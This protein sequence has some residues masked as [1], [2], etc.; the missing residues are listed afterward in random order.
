MSSSQPQPSASNVDDPVGDHQAAPTATARSDVEQTLGTCY[1]H[2]ASQLAL[3]AWRRGGVLHVPAYGD[4]IH[5]I[6]TAHGCSGQD[7]LAAIATLS[8]LTGDLDP[9]G[10]PTLT[11][12]PMGVSSIGHANP[13]DDSPLWRMQRE[14]R[15]V[16]L[17]TLQMTPEHWRRFTAHF[18]SEG[19]VAPLHTL[20]KLGDS[21]SKISGLVDVG[22][23]IDL[24]RSHHGAIALLNTWD[25]HYR[26]AA[27]RYSVTS[28]A[29]LQIPRSKIELHDVT[30][31]A[32]LSNLLDLPNIADRLVRINASQVIF[33]NRI[34][35]VIDR[36]LDT[37]MAQRL[38]EHPHAL[39]VLGYAD[40]DD[41]HLVTERVDV[42][43]CDTTATDIRGEERLRMLMHV[44]AAWETLTDAGRRPP[45]R[46]LDPSMVAGVG[47]VWKLAPFEISTTRDNADVPCSPEELL[48]CSHA[49]FLQRFPAYGRALVTNN[50]RT[51]L[52]SHIQLRRNAEARQRANESLVTA[53]G[54][55]DRVADHIASVVKA[56]YRHVLLQT[57]VEDTLW[58]ESIEESISGAAGK[59]DS[60]AA[61]LRQVADGFFP[62]E[63]P[64][65]APSAIGQKARWHLE[66]VTVPDWSPCA[67]SLTTKSII[68]KTDIWPCLARM[69]CQSGQ[70]SPQAM[71]AAFSA[72]GPS[73]ASP[74]QLRPS[75]TFDYEHGGDRT[76]TT[77]GDLRGL[78]SIPAL[79][80]VWL[81][82]TWVT[83]VRRLASAK[84]L[85]QLHLSGTKVTTEGTMGL[86][87]VPTL[88]TLVLFSTLVTDVRH[89]ASAKA[90]KQL[91]LSSTKMTTEGTMGLERI[92]TLETLDLSG[93]PITDVR[94]LASSKALKLLDLNR[95]KVTVEGTMGLERI[96][97]LEKLVLSFTPI[98]DVR[99]LAS[100]KAL[101]HLDLSS[102]KVTTEGTLGLECMPT[103]E[104]LL[105]SSVLIAD[106]RHLASAKALKH[107]DLRS[108]GMTTEGTMGLERIP[109]LE[110]LVL[111]LTSITDVRHLASAKALKHLDLSSTKVTTEGTM[112]LECMPTL[113][114]LLLSSVLIADVR[115]LASAKA[116]KHLDLSSTKVTTEG[117]TELERIPTLEM[118]LLSSTFV[119]DVRHLAS[120]KALK[121]LDLNSTKVTAEGTMGLERIP[122]LEILYLSFTPI[123][124][125]RHLA[126]AKRLQRL[127]LRKTKVTTEG[128]MGLESIP[129]LE[130]LLLWSTLVTDV[131]HLASAKTLML[132]DLR[133]TKVTTEGTMG[134]ERI[135]TLETL[136]LSETPITDVR[137][138]AS[139]KGLKKLDLSDTKVTAA[140]MMGL[141][142]AVEAAQPI[143]NGSGERR[144]RRSAELKV[145]EGGD[146]ADMLL[147]RTNKP[148]SLVEPF[149]NIP[150]G[151][152][153]A[154]GGTAEIYSVVGQ[155]DT[156]AKIYHHHVLSNEEGYHRETDILQSLRHD[157]IVS[158]RSLI[159]DGDV[160]RGY[161]MEAMDGNLLNTSALTPTQRLLALRQCAEGLSYAHSR[162]VTHGDVKPENCLVR[163]RNDVVTAKVCDF[164]MARIQST[165]AS[166][167]MRGGTVLYAAPEG[168]TH[169]KAADVFAFGLTMWVVLSGGHDHGLGDSIIGVVN[170]LREGRR[171]PLEIPS[172]QDLP[173]N[174]S[175]CALLQQCWNAAPTLRP[176]MADVM[177][178]LQNILHCVP[179]A[180]T[181]PE[182]TLQAT[183]S[184]TWSR[185]QRYRVSSPLAAD[186]DLFQRV[187]SL[188]HRDR[189]ASLSR[190]GVRRVQLVQ[191]DDRDVFWRIHRA[192]ASSLKQSQHLSVAPPSSTAA[193]AASAMLKSF[194]ATAAPHLQSLVNAPANDSN[195]GLSRIVFAWHGTHET[196]IDAVCR[197][198]LRPL[199]STDGGFF[200]IGVYLAMEAE[201]AR[202]YARATSDQHPAT[203]ILYACSV[204]QVYPVTVEADYRTATEDLGRDDFGM[205]RFYGK[206]IKAKF[207]AHFIP[208]RDCGKCHPWDGTTSTIQ[209]YFLDY[210]AATE[211]HANPALHPTAH[212]LVL[213]SGL[214]CTPV[215]LVEVGPHGIA[216][217]SIPDIPL[218]E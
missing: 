147:R 177:L 79:E 86:E 18:D 95:T 210:Q 58:M 202:Q 48:D 208:V 168:N 77:T 50:V 39:K 157:Y 45:S 206:P 73:P 4:L 187:A 24:D 131:R 162:D 32:S 64:L 91:D 139:A 130:N 118:L 27:R 98:T 34:V 154:S 57:T 88:E 144:G 74:W 26:N 8:G 47:S 6:V 180:T 196:N 215:A 119:T 172:L 80:V 159:K 25:E 66:D 110:K 15:G 164:G 170:G 85:K 14:G 70:T 53:G 93:T 214:R 153:L 101:K 203:L 7:P 182:R 42:W 41:R 30:A 36:T 69:T 83:D 174:T 51:C 31:P 185:P 126:S 158:I 76:Q 71:A 127:D 188:V 90:L 122:T 184:L 178:K 2:A 189:D 10:L 43:A 35:T 176:T 12:K 60:F 38:R 13:I 125:V 54:V 212:E 209:G 106:V 115:H 33:E 124:D 171:P 134:L 129:T 102:T 217:P 87:C 207:D 22:L 140:G 156:L 92:P 59:L 123:T 65:P 163:V 149:E 44:A 37:T 5:T 155:A 105:L 49:D 63:S 137:H 179:P 40:K 173:S 138:L 67:T 75:L 161:L 135:P 197:D 148:S 145:G 136:Y 97:T 99:H 132:L 29:A 109:T 213:S 46:E 211:D 195:D 103:L 55:M 16:A 1:A 113:E 194:A 104:T 183:T 68:E 142:R 120:A 192:E 78:E 133:T 61:Q 56:I 200:G 186:H 181:A 21:E 17:L 165:M 19:T 11:S 143:R 107:L 112:G 166:T 216:T 128:T 108:T 23:V 81:W 199:Q 84:A 146:A 204:S 167:T 160:V 94:H 52:A 193:K 151:P 169:P 82:G 111:S 198:G 201:Y 218:G 20:T 114:T 89:L 116:L 191:H 150:L 152:V 9:D 205:S 96:P 190:C 28:L 72:G 100:A 175:V 117:T 141:E 62:V 3:H 121:L